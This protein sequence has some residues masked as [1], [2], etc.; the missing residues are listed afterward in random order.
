MEGEELGLGR[1]LGRGWGLGGGGGGI[2]VWERRLKG[3][4]VKSMRFSC[5]F[6]ET[7]NLFAES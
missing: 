5:F 6:T 2:P 4:G 3:R 1:W 7:S